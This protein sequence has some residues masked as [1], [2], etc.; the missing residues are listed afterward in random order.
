MSDSPGVREQAHSLFAFLREIVALRGKTVRS[1]DDG[2]YELVKWLADIPDV[3]E[4][5]S[6]AASEPDVAGKLPEHWIEIRKPKTKPH[7]AIP[8]SLRLWLDPADVADSARPYPELRDES[9]VE[10]ADSS[11]SESS[12]SDAGRMPPGLVPQV[13]DEWEEYVDKSWQPWAELDRR[14]QVVQGLYDDLFLTY[15]KLQTRS[16]EVELLMG[17]GALSWK[18]PSG[19]AVKRHLVTVRCELVFDADRGRIALGPSSEGL[20]LVL[21]QDMLDVDEQPRPSDANSIRDDLEEVAGSFWHDESL[22]AVLRSWANSVASTGEY[23]ESDGHPAPMTDTPTVSWSPAIILRKRTDRPILDVY[24]RIL[25]LIEDDGE[26]PPGVEALVAAD[27]SNPSPLDAI[28][29]H[30]VEPADRV[31]FPLEANAEQFRIVDRLAA[32]RGLLV[33]GPPGTGKSHTIANLIA[34]FLATGQRVLVTS[35]TPRALRVL[36]D[37]M[38]AEIADLCVLLVGD[39]RAAMTDMERSVQAITD[40]YNTWDPDENRNRIARLEEQ[41]DEAMRREARA[42]GDLVVLREGEVSEHGA[43]AGTYSGTPQAIA[44]Q[45]A[46]ESGRYSWLVVSNGNDEAAEPPLS[47]SQALRL[48]D[49]ARTQAAAETD[50]DGQAVPDLGVVSAAAQFDAMVA[51]EARAKS[52][53]HALTPEAAEDAV[54]AMS[55]ASEEDLRRAIEQVEGLRRARQSCLSS[56]DEWCASAV[57]QTLGGRSRVWRELEVSTRSDLAGIDALPESARAAS[58]TGVDDR[59]PISVRADAQILL[60]HL[61]NGG[62]LGNRLLRP[63]VVKERWYLIEQVRVDGMAADSQDVLTTLVQWCDH[64]LAVKRLSGLWAPYAAPMPE[65]DHLLVATIRDCHSLLEGIVDLVEELA[66]AKGAL[67]RVKGATEPEWQEDGAVAGLVPSL[68]AA[69]A[70]SRFDEASAAIDGLR[71]RVRSSIE[72]GD[73]HPSTSCLLQS[74]DGRDVAAFSAAREDLERLARVEADAD[75]LQELCARLEPI[76][77]SSLAAVLGGP[78]APVWDERLGEFESAWNWNRASKWLEGLTDLG[79]ME[80]SLSHLESFRSRIRDLATQLAEAKAWGHCFEHLTEHERKHL[81]AWMQATRRIGKGT[82]KNAPRHRREARANMEQCRTAIPA[83]VMPIYRV[84]E[85]ITPGGD[86]FD[87]IIVDEASQ[88]GIDALF[89]Q[90]LGK[91]LLIVGDNKQIAPEYIG[92]K[93][94]AVQE[95]R[96]RF[97]M[98]LPVS[99]E[100]TTESSLFDQALVHYRSSIRLKEHFRCMPE[101]IEFS[102]QLSYPNDPLIPLRQ[103]GADRLTPIRRVH[104]ADGYQEGPTGRVTN[105]PEAEAVVRAITDCCRD[106]RYEGL[107]MG[108]ISLLGEAQAKRIERA[109]IRELGPTEMERR[110][111][112]CGDAY[113]FQ[114]DERDIMYLS[115]VS[116][117]GDG[118][119]IGALTKAKDERRF[120]VAA[121][122]AKD[123]LWLFHSVLPNDL[124]PGCMRTKLLQYCLHP[125]VDEFVRGSETSVE[126]VR[127][128]AAEPR[129]PGSQPDPFDSWFEVDVFLHLCG[130]GFRVAPQYEVAGYRID[131]VVE[132]GESRLAVEC[133]GDQWHGPERYEA[134]MARQRQLER[135]GWTFWRLRGSEFYRD[136]EVALA[137]LWRLLE[138]RGIRPLGRAASEVSSSTP[139]AD[140]EAD[141]YVRPTDGEAGP[142]E[143]DETDDVRDDGDTRLSAQGETERDRRAQTKHDELGDGDPDGGG[144]HHPQP[145][146]SSTD[147]DPP[148]WEAYQQGGEPQALPGLSGRQVQ[149]ADTASDAPPL[150]PD[151]E[152]AEQAGSDNEVGAAWLTHGVLGTLPAGTLPTLAPYRVAKVELDVYPPNLVRVARAKLAEVVTRVVSVESP[153]LISEVVCRVTK[154]PRFGSVHRMTQGAFQDAVTYAAKNRMVVRRG[155]V[156]WSKKDRAAVV[157]DR[158]HG[159]KELRLSEAVPTEEIEWAVHVVIRRAGS[160]RRNDVALKASRILGF[161]QTTELL[162]SRVGEAIDR[163]LSC[164]AMTLRDGLLTVIGPDDRTD[165]PPIVLDGHE[166]PDVEAKESASKQSTHSSTRRAA[167]R[168]HRRAEESPSVLVG[169]AQ[170]LIRALPASTRPQEVL[171]EIRHLGVASVPPLVKALEDPELAQL[172][173]TALVGFGPL[174]KSQLVEALDSPNRQ[175]R[176][177]A[178]KA[179]SRAHLADDV[180]DIHQ[181]PVTATVSAATGTVKWFNK[182][183]GYGLISREDGD[184]LYVHWRAIQGDGFKTLDEGQKVTFE[185]TQGAS[186]K[187]QASNVCKA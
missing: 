143:T 47:D 33:Q 84:A 155:D 88:S 86:Q 10:A 20:H 69:V 58:V 57:R 98:D 148:L 174:A 9:L 41:L 126:D 158:R 117:V 113:S 121:S 23:H 136:P 125:R 106:A 103:F 68:E 3:R 102:N 175:V 66:S 150:D 39:D 7:P 118:H 168:P 74:I 4:C 96:Q 31:Y 35:Q 141:A 15:Q 94:D 1:V 18:T 176:I 97:I 144:P 67:H 181:E 187:L 115:M 171:A 157:R 159:P 55:V 137:G 17:L 166:V 122:R 62:G 123:Q 8:P 51:E 28:E 169:R 83:W 112:V 60:E 164:R 185:V 149:L 26:I 76:A 49:L 75:E 43:I 82:G 105:G 133:D 85:S 22:H 186:G 147:A 87:V 132:G 153:I 120:N 184:D 38:P 95:L 16:E 107:T 151:K 14:T 99:S 142:A 90:F 54:A 178:A 45:L 93:S 134:D 40:R 91:K 81:M 63:K 59:E 161:D 70:H 12:G 146:P 109:L 30:S 104:V 108:V 6:I 152:A 167:Q 46:S 24:G 61:A 129:R 11:S 170:D 92:T 111:L 50:H 32:T 183:K 139:R 177:H 21:E 140:A 165:D 156:L 65:A 173:E 5:F 179:L 44:E 100:F 119:R 25:S 110:R 163:A 127:R 80:S 78:D 116:A 71:D 130:R 48:L 53:A 135:C 101:I 154:A 36:K 128:L 2:D 180:S 77:P 29:E 160:A 162:R 145:E 19:H 89:L 131:L 124:H 64:R 52:E 72:G 138:R 13:L 37:K 42:R 56:G 182:A 114:G 34:H 172:A 79:A 27:E 73:L